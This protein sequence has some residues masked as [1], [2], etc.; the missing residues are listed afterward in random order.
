TDD[1]VAPAS[2]VDLTG[3]NSATDLEVQVGNVRFDPVTGRYT[4][5]LRLHNTGAAVG[6]QVAVVF[7]GLPAGV[8]L[9]NRSGVDTG[10]S[11]YV[12]FR[13]AIAAGGL[14]AGTVSSAIEVIFSNP[15]AVR[16]RLLPDVLIGGTNRAPMF[17]TVGP[18]TV[19][20]G[21]V[22]QV[23]LHATDPDGDHVAFSV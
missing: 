10:G 20:P 14:G 1:E 17:D 12:N 4:A 21:G 18:L 23:P 16:F 8:E 13:D 22:L 15:G 2:V 5:D 3:M 11:P 6:R 7:P 9:V 19:S